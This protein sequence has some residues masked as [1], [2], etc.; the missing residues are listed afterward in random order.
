MAAVLSMLI[1]LYLNAIVAAHQRNRKVIPYIRQ[2]IGSETKYIVTET[3]GF[4]QGLFKGRKRKI[5]IEKRKREIELELEVD[6]DDDAIIAH[7]NARMY[8]KHLH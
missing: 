8:Y 7:N 4:F 1:Y 2:N 6:D 5:E 3:E